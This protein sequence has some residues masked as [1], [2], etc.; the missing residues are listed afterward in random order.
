MRNDEENHWLASVPC[1]YFR[2]LMLLAAR[3]EGHPAC[4][5]LYIYP[6]RYP[7]RT[8]GMADEETERNQLTQVHLDNGC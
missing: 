3:Q 1:I 7:S 6:Q 8:G 5:N 2:A 4:K